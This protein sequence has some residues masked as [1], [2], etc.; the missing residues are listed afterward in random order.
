MAT[1]ELLD[2]RRHGH[3]RLRTSTAPPPHFVQVV[4]AEFASAATCCPIFFTKEAATGSFYAGAM[5][6]F[7]PGENL[8]GSIEERGGFNPLMLQRDGFFISEQNIAIDREHARFSDC[9]G[10]P[11]FDA[12]QQPGDALRTI[13][14]TLGEIHHGLEQTQAFIAALSDLKLIE[15]I[16]ISLSFDGAER[17]TLQ[18]LYTVSLDRLRD[19]DDASVL[20]LFRAGHLQLAYTMAASLKQVARLARLRNRRKAQAS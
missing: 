6:G 1:L 10:E 5:F 12:S 17:L 19:L 4:A 3:L 7:K 8:L 13:Q 16:D 14:R 2:P 15:S 18:G 20:R 9:E 11:L